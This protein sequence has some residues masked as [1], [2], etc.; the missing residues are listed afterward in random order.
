[1]TKAE[2]KNKIETWNNELVFPEEGEAD[3][4]TIEVSKE[5]MSDFFNYLKDEEGLL[6]D[7]LF[8]LTGV[9]FGEDLGVVYH[10]ESME[11]RHMIQVTVKTS[12]RE[13]PELDSIHKIFPAAYYNEMEAHEF[14]GVKFKGHPDLKYLFLPEDWDNGFPMRKDY[15]DEVNMLIR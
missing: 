12:D 3:F 5:K 10:L 7:Y 6:F 8:A 14:F 13:N 11:Y 4:L 15:V 2:L 1:M 9:D